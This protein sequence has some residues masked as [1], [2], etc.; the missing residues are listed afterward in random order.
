VSGLF[1][2]PH[3]WISGPEK[4]LR[5]FSFCRTRGG[6]A[7]GQVYNEDRP[8]GQS[9]TSPQF[10]SSNPPTFHGRRQGS[11]PMRVQALGAQAATPST[12]RPTAERRR[13]SKLSCAGWL[14]HDRGFVLELPLSRRRASAWSRLITG[15]RILHRAL[16]PTVD[17]DLF[18]DAKSGGGTDLRLAC[19]RPEKSCHLPRDCGRHD[20][21]GLACSPPAG[22]IGHRA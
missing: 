2:R 18:T 20:D 10:P 4:A 6:I 11:V 21:L 16:P 1:S 19:N 14:P 9:A 22:D 17:A 7:H 15:A 13:L 12:A 5:L 8:H 3:P